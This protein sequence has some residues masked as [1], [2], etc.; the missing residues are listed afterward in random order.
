M[1]RHYLGKGITP[2]YILSLPRI[3]KVFYT[4]CYARSVELE[5]EKIKLLMGRDEDG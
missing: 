5:V 4:A 2:E 1:L 3:N